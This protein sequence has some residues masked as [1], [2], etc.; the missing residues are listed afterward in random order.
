LK[1]YNLS[2]A[3]KDRESIENISI[4]VAKGDI[5][6][7]LGRNGAGTSIIV[8]MLIGLVKPSSGSIELFGREVGYTEHKHLC[9]IGSTAGMPGL[10]PNL[11]VFENLDMHRKLMKIPSGSSTEHALD[12]LKIRGYKNHLVKYLSSGMRQKVSIARALVHN[13]ELLILD[14]PTYALDPAEI[15]DV[16]QLLLNLSLYQNTAVVFSSHMLS[17]VEQIASKIGVVSNGKLVEEIDPA[18]FGKLNRNYIEIRVNDSKKA[19]FLLE[20]KLELFEYEIVQRDLVRVYCGNEHSANINRVLIEEG[21][22]VFE[23]KCIRHTLEE[24]FLSLTGG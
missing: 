8:R 15:R 17:E 3:L 9:R 18:D 14:D 10:Y 4:K 12:K 7:L 11:T 23:I 13:P 5:Y 19:S 24:R 1:T 21:I 16:R 2:K 6:A 20:Q 22:D